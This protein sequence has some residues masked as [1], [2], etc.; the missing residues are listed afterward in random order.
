MF[1]F[2]LQLFPAIITNVA[3]PLSFSVSIIFVLFSDVS[4]FPKLVL[5]R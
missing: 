3:F 1:E 2:T 5:A 4:A